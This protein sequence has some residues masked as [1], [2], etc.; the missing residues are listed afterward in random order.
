MRNKILIPIKNSFCELLAPLIG[1]PALVSSLILMATYASLDCPSYAFPLMLLVALT[2]HFFTRSLQIVVLT[3]LFA[4]ILSYNYANENFPF[5]SNKDE[6]F[7]Q[8]QNLVEPPA[9]ACGIVEAIIP[10]AKGNAFVI[11]SKKG[12]LTYRVRITDKGKTKNFRFEKRQ[13]GKKQVEKI[14]SRNIPHL[15]NYQVDNFLVTENS[16][17]KETPAEDKSPMVLRIHEK[18]RNIFFGTAKVGVVMSKEKERKGP[19]E[20]ALQYYTEHMRE[21]LQENGLC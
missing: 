14:R 8:K 16:S 12:E 5:F 7:A 1:K 11:K 19:A 18:V 9:K 13:S 20:N 3:S 15:L 17:R 10:R 21:L 4:G 6:N 2:N